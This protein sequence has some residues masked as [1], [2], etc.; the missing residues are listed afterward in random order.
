MIRGYGFNKFDY[1]HIIEIIVALTQSAT[2]ASYQVHPYGGTFLLR[3]MRRRLSC[4]AV[5]LGCG[6]YTRIT[7]RENV[8]LHRGLN[9]CVAYVNWRIRI[10]VTISIIRYFFLLDTS[11]GEPVIL[12]VDRIAAT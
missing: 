7:C 10:C 2:E 3:S 12:I 8:F 1:I 6:N 11:F 4:F 5:T 9:A